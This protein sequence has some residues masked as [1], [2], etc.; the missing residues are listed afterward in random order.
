MMLY[1]VRTYTVGIGKQPG[2]L[3]LFEEVGYDI[4]C[5]YMTP[6]G[7]FYAETGGLNRVRHIW[8]HESRSQRAERRDALYQDADWMG[9][10]IPYALPNLV[11]QETR[12]F[13]LPAGASPP[14]I[15]VASGAPR[16][17]D[18]VESS[19][20]LPADLPGRIAHFQA[21]DGVVGSE[22]MILAHAD[23]AARDRLNDDLTELLPSGATI[24]TFHPTTFS[25]TR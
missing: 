15:G 7:F 23:G 19:S 12:L 9:S 10:F 18:M 8:M 2:Y 22:M 5:R 13:C 20:A 24:E 21:S 11:S 4:L 1:E 6:V 16:L 25:A 3:K 17:F 14:E